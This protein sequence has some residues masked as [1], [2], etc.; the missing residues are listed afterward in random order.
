MSIRVPKKKKIKLKDCTLSSERKMK[1]KYYFDYMIPN[2]IK[3]GLC[4]GLYLTILAYT[5]LT[6]I[7]VS[8][9]LKPNDMPRF[10]DNCGL[11]QIK[12]F[13]ASGG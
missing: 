6:V 4:S 2:W 11:D 9:V 1:L 12:Y 10:P 13:N 7:F 5:L 8:R 3:K